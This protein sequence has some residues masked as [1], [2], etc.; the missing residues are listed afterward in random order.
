MYLDHTFTAVFP[1]AEYAKVLYSFQIRLCWVIGRARSAR[2]KVRRVCV[3]RGCW[4]RNERNISQMR[5][6]LLSKITAR[7]KS[8]LTLRY[9]TRW[10]E[11][12]RPLRC[13]IRNSR[14]YE[15]KWSAGLE[16]LAII[17]METYH[18]PEFIG[19]RKLLASALH[20]LQEAVRRRS[21]DVLISRLTNARSKSVPCC[22]LNSM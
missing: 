1:E 9:S 10:I 12:F 4:S 18:L 15:A 13:F 7:S 17:D 6:I 22:C 2:S 3:T 20:D 16:N 14:Y 19:P 21:S 5:G 11:G 8:A